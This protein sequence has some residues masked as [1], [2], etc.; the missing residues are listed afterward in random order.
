MLRRRVLM[1]C[2]VSSQCRPV[3]PRG[4][5]GARPVLTPAPHTEGG[6][7]GAPDAVEV[8]SSA[9][10]RPRLPRPCDASP[11][12]AVSR[13]TAVPAPGAKGAGATRWDRRARGVLAAR[14]TAPEGVL[15]PVVVG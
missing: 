7:D 4:K 10:S 8:V 2:A 3:Y 12:E 15:D 11:V 5:H 13:D 9:E 6:N 1:L 14:Q